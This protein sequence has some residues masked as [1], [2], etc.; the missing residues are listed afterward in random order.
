MDVFNRLN[1]DKTK[2]LKINL[3]G[4]IWQEKE[5]YYGFDISVINIRLRRYISY[6]SN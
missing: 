6:Y 4:V 5:C 2:L 3:I 1:A